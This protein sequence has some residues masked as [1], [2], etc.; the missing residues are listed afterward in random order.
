M[1]HS[2]TAILDRIHLEHGGVPLAVTGESAAMAL[3][4]RGC[5]SAE[6]GA[7]G[8]DGWVDRGRRVLLGG[9]PDVVA[10]VAGVP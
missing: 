4:P 2:T 7:F 1:K 5:D 8:C 10:D 9:D 6:P 3:P